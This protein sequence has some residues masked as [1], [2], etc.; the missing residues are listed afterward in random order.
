MRNFT[1]SLVLAVL[2]AVFAIHIN[3]KIDTNDLPFAGL[4]L[5]VI[6][7]LSLLG[8]LALATLTSLLTKRDLRVWVAGA[9][10]LLAVFFGTLFTAEEP[11]FSQWLFGYAVAL[12]LGI[13][14]A[15]RKPKDTPKPAGK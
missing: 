3:I 10:L 14:W 8:T 4:G 9:Q 13:G 11:L 1:V 15:S 5:L 7:T 6:G 12:L 2:V